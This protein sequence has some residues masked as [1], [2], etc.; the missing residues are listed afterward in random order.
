LLTGSRIV[1][2]YDFCKLPGSVSPSAEVGRLID[3]TKKGRA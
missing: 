3:P 2:L 1:Q